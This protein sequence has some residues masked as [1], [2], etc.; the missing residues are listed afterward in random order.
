MRRIVTFLLLIAMA[1]FATGLTE[2]LHTQHHEYEDAV[3]AAAALEKSHAPVPSPH[4]HSEQDCPICA[5]FHTP[6]IATA[7]AAWL[8]DT[9]VWVRYVS[10]LAFSQQSQ[11]VPSSLSCRGPPAVAC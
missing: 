5:Q 9:G 1:S 4:K 11:D 2:R 10:M 3:A 6:I 8:I 7:H